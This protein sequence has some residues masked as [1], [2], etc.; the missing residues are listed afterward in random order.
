MEDLVLQAVAA[1]KKLDPKDIRV[2]NAIERGMARY[3]IVPIHQIARLAGLNV[4]E[5]SIRL[6][7]L[8]K[9]NLIWRS[10]GPYVGYVLKVTGY[11]CLALNALSKANIVEA[12]GRKL[13]VGKE[14]DVYD[15]LSPS[16]EKIALKFH[17]LGRTSF[18][19]TRRYRIYVGERRHISWLYQ[20]RLAAEKEYEALNLLYP[21]VHVPTP[22]GH[23]RHVVVTSYIHGVPLYEVK[24]LD[25][26]KE[27][28][29]S[30]IDDI[31][32]SYKIGVVHGDLS[33]YNIIIDPESSTYVIIDWPQ[34]V[35]SVHPSAELLL[36]RDVRNILNFF[37]RRFNI[38]VDLESTLNYVKSSS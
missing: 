9:L 16:G 29:D 27:L 36:K 21:K 20:S 13:G 10:I 11:D 34:W 30:I 14:A 6:S 33:E 37:R 28:L 1:L 8:H 23:N 12:I 35:P 18:R 32:T 26:P 19:Q 5:T 38:R 24:E 15:A 2:L 3:E 31:K 4:E 22:I 17:R 7:K 25:D